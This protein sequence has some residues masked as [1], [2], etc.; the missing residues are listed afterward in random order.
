MTSS[1]LNP[2]AEIVAY[3]HQRATDDVRDA[4][5]WLDREGFKAQSGRGGPNESFGN[6]LLDLTDDRGVTV[7]I[8][9]DRSQWSCEIGAKDLPKQPLNV[10]T[11]AMNGEPPHIPPGA[12]GDPL[13]TQLPDGLEWA[14][15]IPR[16]IE[17]LTAR[18]RRDEIE[19]ASTQWRAAMKRW[20]KEQGPR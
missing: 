8:V 19:S 17:W 3:A 1:G 10:L 18:D 20:W 4:L 14:T 16:I 15:A 13:P 2:Y 6:L 7:E 12:L 11:T 9:R 5:Q